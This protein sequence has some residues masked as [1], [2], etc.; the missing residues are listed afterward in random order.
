MSWTLHYSAEALEDLKS[1]YE[2][3]AFE[4]QAPDTAAK[5]TGRIKSAVKRLVDM[6]MLYKLYD[7]EPWRSKG[8]RIFTVDN[9][10]VLYLPN[11][12]RKS[13]NVIRI[14]YG[15]RDIERQLEMTKGI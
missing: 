8:L 3:I 11:E 9:Y 6:P 10:S 14:M 7:V 13:V 1:I 2:Y 15:G 5:Q 12:E 4:L